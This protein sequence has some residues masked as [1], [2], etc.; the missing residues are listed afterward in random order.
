MN[1]QIRAEVEKPFVRSP[2][3]NPPGPQSKLGFPATTT[4]IQYLQRQIGNQGLQRVLTAMIQREPPKTAKAAPLFE[5]ATTPYESAEWESKFSEEEQKW[6]QQVFKLPEFVQMFKAYPGLPKIV[7]HRVSQMESG[8]N[9]QFSDPDIALADK[10][11]NKTDQYPGADHKPRKATTEEQFKGTLIHE[12]THFF[13]KHTKDFAATQIVLELLSQAMINPESFNLKPFAFGW[14]VHPKSQYILHFDLPE[15]LSFNPNITII[16][17]PLM[18]IRKKKE[19]E[20]SPMPQSGNQINTNE[21]IAQSMSLY[22]TSAASR[23][24]LQTK[25]PLRYKLIAGYF[26]VLAGK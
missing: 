22:L 3:S 13:F 12:L 5:Y 16:G 11:Y 17:T 8:A 19:Y 26:K 7:L 10:L 20:S 21:D 6:I 25:Y 1:S 23:E 4:K 24:L 2:V 18:E 15:I 9:G 14:F